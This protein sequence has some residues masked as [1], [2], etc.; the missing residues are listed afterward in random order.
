M[1]L[2]KPGTNYDFIGKRK[3]AYIVSLA[4]LVVAV[5][6]LSFTGG[7]GTASTSPGVT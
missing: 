3:I 5:V 4:L 2:I 7:R 6:S 1:E